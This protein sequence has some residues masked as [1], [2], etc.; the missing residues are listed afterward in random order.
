MT[1]LNFTNFAPEAVLKNDVSSSATT[2]N[3][4]TVAGFPEFPY[5]VI[6]D[7]DLATEE[8]MLVTGTSGAPTVLEVVRGVG[9]LGIAG[10]PAFEHA[11]GSS[12]KHGATASDFNNMAVIY[13]AL[14]DG[15]GGVNPPLPDKPGGL[16]W[17]D[18]L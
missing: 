8:I 14:S 13:E 18:L 5:T 10:G 16:V 6:V 1:R 3:V 12:V 15:E 17:A 11:A 9:D 2:I 7:S 4:D